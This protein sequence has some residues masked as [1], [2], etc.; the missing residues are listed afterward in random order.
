MTKVVTKFNLIFC[1]EKCDVVARFCCDN[2]CDK[3]H[4]DFCEREKCDVVRQSNDFISGNDGAIKN[5]GI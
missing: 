3:I 5:Y 2:C 1:E 4:F